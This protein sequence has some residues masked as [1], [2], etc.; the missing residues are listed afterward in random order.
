MCFIS[1]YFNWIF[2]NYSRSWDREFSS[3]FYWSTLYCVSDHSSKEF[4]GS[5]F[6]FLFLLIHSGFAV[7]KF[8][9]LQLGCVC[10]NLARTQLMMCPSGKI[11]N[12]FCKC[13]ASRQTGTSLM[14]RRLWL[15][16][17]GKP[18]FLTR[19]SETDTFLSPVNYFLLPFWL[20]DGPSKVCFMVEPLTPISML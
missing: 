14:K 6:L 5:P 9:H 16:F 7:L 2:K 20:R 18:F 10:G 11:C 1:T 17:S 12:G 3:L 15:Q 4:F 13:W 19:I 8:C